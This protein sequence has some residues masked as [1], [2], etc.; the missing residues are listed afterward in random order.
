[1]RLKFRIHYKDI[2]CID[3]EGDSIEEIRGIA[4][5]ET[6]RRNWDESFC[7]SERLDD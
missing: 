1:M 3:I 5:A 7:W 6:T 4:K 2:D